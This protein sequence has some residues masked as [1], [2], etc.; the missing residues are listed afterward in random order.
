MKQHV[1]GLLKPQSSFPACL[2]DLQIGSTVGFRSFLVASSRKADIPCRQ[3]NP[4][5]LFA[6]PWLS[7]ESNHCCSGG[8]GAVSTNESA[9]YCCLPVGG[10]SW[11]TLPLHFVLGAGVCIPQVTPWIDFCMVVGLQ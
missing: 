11:G 5:I 7:S 4:E 10:A 9:A 6:L 1:R 8:G 2:E 3:G